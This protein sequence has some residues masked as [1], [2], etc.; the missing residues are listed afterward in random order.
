MRLVPCAGV[1]KIARSGGTRRN[2]T[3]VV[4]RRD[5]SRVAVCPTARRFCVFLQIQEFYSRKEH[6]L[7]L[8]VFQRVEYDFALAALSH[9]VRRA[10]QTELVRTGGLIE[11]Q[12]TGKVADAHFRYGKSAD[13]FRSRR[14]AAR[15][16]ELR[17]RVQSRVSGNVIANEFN[18]DVVEQGFHSRIIIRIQTRNKGY[19]E[20]KGDN[21][22]VF[23]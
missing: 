8:S 23:E 19:F 9:Y 16:K 14:V 13:D 20:R 11:P 6:V 17:K 7:Y 18:G 15:G 2:I 12:H 4:C 1:K 5:G 22:V 3:K 10:K 21:L